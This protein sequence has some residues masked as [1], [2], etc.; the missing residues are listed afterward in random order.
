MQPQLRVTLEELQQLLIANP[1]QQPVGQ[2][3]LILDTRSAAQYKAEV[4]SFSGGLR[5]CALC[6]CCSG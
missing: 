5:S 2:Q 4:S 1:A 6:K 3:A